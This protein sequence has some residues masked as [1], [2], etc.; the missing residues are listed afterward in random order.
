M[1]TDTSPTNWTLAF[2][3]LAVMTLTAIGGTAL[4]TTTWDTAID[5]PQTA[6]TTIGD[7]WNTITT[8]ITQQATHG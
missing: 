2:A 4:V 3:A 8:W 1:D 5:A 7:T 6:M